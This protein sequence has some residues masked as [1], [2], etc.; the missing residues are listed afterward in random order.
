MRVALTV[1]SL[2]LLAGCASGPA[3]QSLTN[4][5]VVLEVLGKGL[6]KGDM[7][8]IERYVAED[9][10]QHNPSAADGRAGLIE[11]INAR[12]PHEKQELIVVRIFEEGEYV[13]AHSELV[14]TSTEG[15]DWELRFALMDLWRV[16]DGRLV[17]H[18]DAMQRQPDSTASG[19][20]MLDGPTQAQEQSRTA[21]N[22]KL[23]REFVDAVLVNGDIDRIGDFIE[24]E[25]YA[26][27]NPGAADGATALSNF[28]RG[29]RQWEKGFA[30]E[31]KRVFAQGNFVLVQARGT[32]AG[33]PHAVYDLFRCE[34]GKVVE[35]W[36]VIQEIPAESRNNN[37]MV[38]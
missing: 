5:E 8:I 15:A 24:G 9:Y 38:D 3:R 18:W 31:V 7:D 26:Q 14:V 12:S 11:F 23:V 33:K 16:Q 37:G 6:A 1:L 17:E 36:D 27:H 35:H 10:R 32:F 28:L 22:K 13:W 25:N 21:A 19:R 20:S 29:A 34:G 4:S 2:C 30:Y